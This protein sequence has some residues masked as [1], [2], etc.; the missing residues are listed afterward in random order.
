MNTSPYTH[1][2]IKSNQRCFFVPP[3]P[4]IDKSCYER[5][6]KWPLIMMESGQCNHVRRDNLEFIGNDTPIAQEK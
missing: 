4:T 1:K 2:I 6:R 3:W 5:D